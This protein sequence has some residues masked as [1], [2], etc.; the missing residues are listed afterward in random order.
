MTTNTSTT[1]STGTSTDLRLLII[2]HL[3]DVLDDLEMTDEN[4]A[5]YTDQAIVAMHD[6]NVGLSA[7]LVASLGLTDASRDGEGY[8]VRLNIQEAHSF[9]DTHVGQDI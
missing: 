7:F 3:A 9:V 4:E 8:L 1:P 2:E 6:R 5:E